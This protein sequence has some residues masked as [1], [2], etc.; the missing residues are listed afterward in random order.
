M[1][2]RELTDNRYKMVLEETWHFELPEVRSS[3]QIWYE[4]IPCE[5]GAFIAVNSLNPLFLE[6]YTPRPKNVKRI[7]Y[8]IK[9]VVG[10]RADFLFEGEARLFFP[11]EALTQVAALA[12]ARR[13]R[14]LSEEQ[15][16]KLIEAGK[17][18][19]LS[20]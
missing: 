1:N 12:E 17:V 10:V 9:G 3:D 2:L 18:H 20:S 8:A 11:L 14:R 19:R 13:R 7:W 16:V 5:G 6:L 15:R 4:Q